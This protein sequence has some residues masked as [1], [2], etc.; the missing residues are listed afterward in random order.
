ME[1]GLHPM[2]G[3]VSNVLWD[4]SVETT[5][6]GAPSGLSLSALPRGLGLLSSYKERKHFRMKKRH[7]LE[8]RQCRFPW[9]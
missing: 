7:A 8:T 9:L 1:G 4:G 5:R 3:K 6:P 2:L